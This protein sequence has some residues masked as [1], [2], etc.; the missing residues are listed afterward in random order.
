MSIVLGVSGSLRNVRF[1]SGSTSLCSELAALESKS[2]LVDYLQKQSKICASNFFEAGRKN[3]QPFDVIYNNLRKSK[4]NQGL[5]NSEASL[6]AG[7]WGAVQ[8]GSEI[9]HCGLARY[10]P[11]NNPGV[12]LDELKATILEADAYLIA[13]PVYFGDR[14]SL[15]QRF[16]KFLRADPELTAHLRDKFHAGI[17]VGAKRNGGQETSLIYLMT[18]MANFNMMAMGND[19]GTTAL[20]GSESKRDSDSGS[21]HEDRFF[22]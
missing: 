16:V 17:S 15:V 18:D 19:S 14:S 13:T 9:R 2:D 22:P 12:H 6:A 8:G 11:P 20:C 10:F 3:N 4:G 5:S 21:T 7:L 1:G